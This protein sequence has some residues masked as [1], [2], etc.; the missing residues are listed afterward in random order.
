MK[1]FLKN[2]YKKMLLGLVILAVG[3]GAFSFF[4]GKDSKTPVSNSEVTTLEKKEFVNSISENGKAVSETSQNVYAEK[5]LPVDEIKVK[6]GDYV[7]EGDIIATLDDSSIKQQIEQKNA[8]IK[9]SKASSGPQIKNAKDRLNEANRNLKDGTNPQI[10]AAEAQL[11]TAYNAWQNAENTYTQTVNAKNGGYSQNA[12][13]ELSNSTSLD[14]SRDNAFLSHDQAIDNYNKLRYTME[15]S[16]QLAYLTKEKLNELK[17][18]DAYIAERIT[19][20][21][22]DINSATTGPDTAAIDNQIKFAKEELEKIKNAHLTLHLDDTTFSQAD[23]IT[24]QNITNLKNKIRDLELEKTNL[25]NAYNNSIPMDTKALQ[26]ELD[27]L[28]KETQL[29]KEELGKVTAENQKYEAEAETAKN[30]LLSAQHQLEQ[31]ELG[32]ISSNK[33]ISTAEKQKNITNKIEKDTIGNLRKQADDLKGQY[34]IAKKNLELAKIAAKDEINSLKNSLN[35]ASAGADNS[36][37]YVDLKFLNE[38]LGKTVIKAPISGTITALNLIKG[39]NP[40]DYVA[41]IET[42]ERIVIET[43]VKEFD[44]NSIK[45]GMD[46]E[47]TS[48]ASGS[49][50]VVVGKVESI[51]PVPKEAGKGASGNSEVAYGVK[52]SLD[53]TSSLIKPGMNVRVKY[54]LDKKPNVFAVPTNAIYKKNEKAFIMYVDGS[55]IKELEV[56]IDG[57]N[58][59]ESVISSQELNENMK[60]INATDKYSPGMEINL[61]DKDEKEN[62]TVQVEL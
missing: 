24:L 48:D 34:E 6:V 15:N 50:E 40:Q 53:K 21:Q 10:T 39:Q 23:P 13:Q 14:I 4:K 41:K 35:I 5:L 20:I 51:N 2:N 18:R 62:P 44:V 54:I 17:N 46:V 47:V 8:M 22:R 61:V 30:Q 9:A 28:N 49:N 27:A 33:N 60:I 25:R 36:L 42:I 31:T 16:S 57:E 32:I 26:A 58:N 19:K 43:Q 7:K 59:F 29:I 45:V 52:V 55:T 11:E 3:Y 56:T 38:D 37:N 12:S 1:T